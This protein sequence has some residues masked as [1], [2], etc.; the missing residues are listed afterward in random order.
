MRTRLAAIAAA[1]LAAT[2]IATPVGAV[3]GNAEED[4]EHDYVG[5][6]VFYTDP[7]PNSVP[8]G[9]PFSHRCSGSLISPTL[10]VTAG[11][12]TEGVDH[13]R[14]YF[15]Q[16]VGPNYSPD[17]FGGWGG[18]ETTGYPYAQGYTFSKTWTFDEIFVGYPSQ[19]D[20]KDLG[21]VELDA[22]YETPSGRYGELPEAGL[23]DELVAEAGAAGKKTLR[24]RTVGYGLLDQ[25]PFPNPGQRERMSAWGYLIEGNSG[26][27]EYNLK[28]TANASNGKGG[29]CNGDSGGP[30][31]VEGTDII[32]AVVSF[33]KNPQCK[34]Q[35]FSYRLD[36]EPVL[37]WI[38]DEDR[39]SAG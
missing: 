39:E 16:A 31:L 4:F 15:N 33:G 12:C 21:L 13:G 35:D 3:T 11:H 5:L 34:G 37:D 29:S 28:T 36:R 20:T 32:A 26:I 9:D 38:A 25:D 22:P 24:F 19:T 6:L 14:I 8:P 7:D 2:M 1:L 17:S 30:V 18:D 23:I 27:T 10:V